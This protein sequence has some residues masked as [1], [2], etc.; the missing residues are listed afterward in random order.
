MLFS[1]YFNESYI[2]YHLK[3]ITEYVMMMIIIIGYVL[4]IGKQF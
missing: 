3:L 2:Y 1:V 4:K